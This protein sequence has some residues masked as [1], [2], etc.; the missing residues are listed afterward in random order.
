MENDLN[1]EIEKYKNELN[2]KNK[3]IID[4]KKKVKNL[5]IYIQKKDQ[6]LLL[7]DNQIKMVEEQNE[8][9][10]SD[11]NNLINETNS[12]NLNCNKNSPF[13][14]LIREL[15]EYRKVNLELNREL[16]KL[17][18]QSYKL[19]NYYNDKNQ[20][21]RYCQVHCQSNNDNLIEK[22]NQ[23]EKENKFLK[24]L[25]KDNNIHICQSKKY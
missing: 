14:D 13:K 4:L 11:Y 25:M 1:R 3:E 6:T 20:I 7:M 15:N 16:V 9:I 5:T 2:E 22:L 21:C 10:T 23:L 12:L 8:Q 17:R 24:N 19:Q 18:E